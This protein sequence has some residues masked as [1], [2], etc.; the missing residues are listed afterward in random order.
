M[1]RVLEKIKTFWRQLG[2]GLITGAADDDPS[3]IVTYAV[4][5][6]KLGLAALWTALATLPFM[7][8]TQRM[9]GRIGL[10]S[11]RGLA[12][13]MKKYYPKWIL[14]IIA[15]LI[16]GANIINIGADI[17]AM[18]ASIN[19]LAPQVPSIFFSALIPLVLVALLILFPYRDMANYLKW[20]AIVMFSYVLAAFFVDLDWSQ[21]LHRTFIPQ[22]VHSKDYLM[23]VVAIFGTTISPYLFFWQASGA[24]EEEVL[25]QYPKKKG[26]VMIPGVE[27]HI[28]H[29]SSHIIKNEI[30]VMYKDVR[31]GMAFSNLIT[32]FIIALFAFTL[33]KAGTFNPSTV[34]EIASALKPMAGPYSNFLFLL[35][36]L[37]A[38]TLAIPV[39]AGSA[40]YALSEMFGWRWGFFNSFHRAK[41]FYLVIIIATLLGIAIPAFRLHPVEILVWTAVIFGL[42]SPP[43]VLLLIHMANNPKIMGKYVSRLHSNI[44]AYILFLIMTGAAILMFAL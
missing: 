10:I 3:G 26:G 36:I 33:F 29:R 44:I 22:I 1:A 32:Y 4:A 41:Q 14:I 34:E 31:Y 19:L 6:A 43:L 37:A 30:S 7:I 16:V 13:N 20:I 8:I 35:G 25:H 15:T 38:G 18:S 28:K 40:A 27:P 2:P 9:A 39:L 11:G 12:G 17:S 21:I 24:V 42:I 23:I 5:G